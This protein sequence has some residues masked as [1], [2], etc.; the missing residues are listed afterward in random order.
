MAEYDFALPHQ[1][2][3]VVGTEISSNLRFSFIGEPSMNIEIEP[4]V[5]RS[6]YNLGSLP[7][8]SDIIREFLAFKIRQMTF[9]NTEKLQ[10]PMARKQRTVSNEIKKKIREFIE[11]KKDLGNFESQKIRSERSVSYIGS[12]I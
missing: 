9:P 6:Q 10:I 2:K 8:V 3:V 4:V 1:L 7:S 11:K 5:G 12:E